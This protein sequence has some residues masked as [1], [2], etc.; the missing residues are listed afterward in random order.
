MV[1]VGVGVGGVRLRLG[2][3]LV[4]IV[5]LMKFLVLI[6]GVVCLVKLVM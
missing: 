4:E 5:M 1:R 6:K 3:F 2:V